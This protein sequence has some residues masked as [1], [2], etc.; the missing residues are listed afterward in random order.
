MVVTL[1]AITPSMYEKL[2]GTST[3]V[4]ANQGFIMRFSKKYRVTV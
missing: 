4:S 3:K 2:S 1:I